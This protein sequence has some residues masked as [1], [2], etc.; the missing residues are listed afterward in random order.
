[1][2][3]GVLEDMS[4]ISGK[5]KHL[6]E[7]ARDERVLNHEGELRKFYDGRAEYRIVEEARFYN[8]LLRRYYRFYV[9]PEK[10]VLEVGCGVGDLLA[11]LE[12]SYGLGLDISPKMIEVARARHAGRNLEWR[13]GCGELRRSAEE[14]SSS[15]LAKEYDL[16][17]RVS[18]DAD[19][20]IRASPFDY[21]VLS[22]LVNDLR[23]VQ[24]MLEALRAH[25]F[26]ETR[27]VINFFNNV[28]RPVLNV[29]EKLR[30]KAPTLMQ[31]WLSSVDMRNLLHLAGWEV[32]TQSQRVLCPVKLPLLG[33]FL[34]RFC[35]PVLGP[36]CLTVF[37]VARL[38]SIARITKE[39]H[40]FDR[41]FHELI[42]IEE[43]CQRKDERPVSTDTDRNVPASLSCSVV[44]P[45]RNEEGNI[46]AAVRRLPGRTMDGDYFCRR[47]ID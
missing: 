3:A 19:R 6:R 44:I 24:G 18:T 21:I 7:S 34:N 37:Q 16:D 11:A 13:V 17:E 5:A 4:V 41:G 33:R 46:E 25:S 22:D 15:E 1:M 9:P 28:W 23:D 2:N 10:R 40:S 43:H 26:A 12:P 29:A 42:Q 36:L 32:V 27:L 45:A 30:L 8:A 35:A 47:G 38:R 14:Y 39:C 31:N 20:N